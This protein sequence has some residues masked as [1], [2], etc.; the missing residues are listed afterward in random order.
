MDGRC[1]VSGPGEDHAVAVE[2][3]AVSHH[4]SRDFEDTLALE[5]GEALLSPSVD[6]C[7]ETKNRHYFVIVPLEHDFADVEQALLIL[8][9]LCRVLIVDLV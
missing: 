6:L 5:H 3:V 1:K 7:S 9:E 2:P 4:D 8:V